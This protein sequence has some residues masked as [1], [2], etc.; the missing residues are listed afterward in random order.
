MTDSTRSLVAIC[1]L[2][3]LSACVDEDR[4]MWNIDPE[5]SHKQLME[6]LG[7]VKTQPSY[8]KE[9]NNG[10]IVSECQEAAEQNAK[11][12]MCY[13]STTHKWYRP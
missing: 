10:H 6:C 2:F 5:L 7:T 9:N 4:C 8:N 13:S 11:R 3:M 12:W 1:A